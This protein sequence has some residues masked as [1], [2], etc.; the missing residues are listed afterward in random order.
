MFVIIWIIISIIVFSVIVLAHEYWHF[1]RARIFGVKVEE[2]WL[3]IPPRAKHIYTDKKWTKYTLNWL[4]IGWFVKLKWEDFKDM[5]EDSINSKNLLK[6]SIIVLAWIT[7]NFLLAVIIFSIL[8]FIWIKPIWINT[9]IE[10]NLWLKIIPTLEDAKKSWLIKTYSWV[11]LSPLEW[12]IAKKS[13]IKEFDLVIKVN[14]EDLKDIKSL[15]SII[16]QNPKNPINL[17]I[18]RRIWECE[19][20]NINKCEKQEIKITLIPDENWKIWSYLIENQE[21]DTDFIYK[22]WFIDSIKAWI[23]ETYGQ[24]ILTFKA[25]K[26]IGEKI[27]NPKTPLERQEAI[28]QI[29]WPIWIIDFITSS[30]SNWIKFILII[31]AIISINLWVFNLLPIPALDWWRFIFI[32]LQSFLSLFW[33]KKYIFKQIE[34]II[35]MMFF[36]FLIALSIIIAYNDINKIINKN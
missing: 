32:I 14:N 9:K 17:T 22:L 6:Q 11:L 23:N 12:S 21:I 35:H 8:F 34:W 19:I 28:S 15:K 27:F 7:M 20:K 13:W 16:S 3:G 1:K 5:S 31:W 26:I 30:Y 33:K 36:I 2:F 4:P 10:N 29:S 24:I 25:L 18:L